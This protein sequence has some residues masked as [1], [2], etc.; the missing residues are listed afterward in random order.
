MLYLL[1]SITVLC[2]MCGKHL[3]ACKRELPCS[4]NGSCQQE[5][6]SVGSE[7]IGS[8]MRCIIK[9]FLLVHLYQ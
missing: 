7:I 9:K 8:F 3:A 2:R 1:F 5:T 6:E 4:G